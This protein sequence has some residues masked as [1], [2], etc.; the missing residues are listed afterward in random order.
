MSLE[1]VMLKM[2]ELLMLVKVKVQ[3]F[4]KKFQ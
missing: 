3:G 1:M 4:E 2:K